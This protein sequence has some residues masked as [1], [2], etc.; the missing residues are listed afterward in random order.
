MT[1][2]HSPL[3]MLKAQ[4]DQIARTIKAAERGEP[5]APEFARKLA[6]ARLRDSF[7]LGVLMD[8]KVLKITI[9]WAT[10]RE[11]SEVALS[12]YVLKQMRGARDQ[13]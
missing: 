7:V 9:P 12:E 10:V 6:E 13:A 2:S 5:I 4:S 3:R 8:D 11:T 1:T